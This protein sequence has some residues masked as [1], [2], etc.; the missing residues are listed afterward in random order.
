M[1]V[2]YK[3][4]CPVAGSLAEHLSGPAYPINQMI[5]LSHGGKEIVSQINRLQIF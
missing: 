2:S 4:L 3:V 5:S 1:N